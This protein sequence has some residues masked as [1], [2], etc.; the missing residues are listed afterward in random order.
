MFCQLSVG[1]IGFAV[2]IPA[3][4]QIGAQ[5]GVTF[6]EPKLPDPHL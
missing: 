5:M 4:A 2:V 1:L 6:F 3:W